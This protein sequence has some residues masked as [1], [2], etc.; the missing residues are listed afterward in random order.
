MTY[1]KIEDEM[2]H[3]YTDEIVCPHCGYEHTD[4]WEQGS[5]NEEDFESECHD[6]GKVILVSRMVTVKY[7]TLI[8]K[9]S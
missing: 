6:C 7:S 9:A 3:S 1:I 2:D 8:P 5:G 4:S